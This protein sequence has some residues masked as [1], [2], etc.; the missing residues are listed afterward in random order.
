MV[1]TI[2]IK[3]VYQIIPCICI[4]SDFGDAPILVNGAS[5]QKS[6]H[7]SINRRTVYK[8]QEKTFKYKYVINKT[9]LIIFLQI[10]FV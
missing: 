10:L 9:L 7:C 5:Y 4:N 2:L 3:T 6:V 8:I 1:E